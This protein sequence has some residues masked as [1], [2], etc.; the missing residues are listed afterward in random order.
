M[1]DNKSTQ[2]TRVNSKT[3]LYTL[4]Q[5]SNEYGEDFEVLVDDPEQPSVLLIAG[6]E[7]DWEPLDYNGGNCLVPLGTKVFMLSQY[8]VDELKGALQ[9]AR[10]QIILNK[11]HTRA[12]RVDTSAQE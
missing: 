11:R 8:E 5:F 9:A 1:T 3:P 2:S 6:D 4:A 10:D 7:T 12:T